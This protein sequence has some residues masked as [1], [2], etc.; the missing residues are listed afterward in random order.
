MRPAFRTASH[1]SFEEFTGR[2]GHAETSQASTSINSFKDVIQIAST[3]L[4][5]ASTLFFVIGLL[6]VN[7]RLSSY[8]VHYL[9]IDRAEYAVGRCCYCVSIRELLL[10]S[11]AVFQSLET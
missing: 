1:S 3:L 11:E 2:D 7:L 6:V 10:C 5:G 4:I 8:G 9:E